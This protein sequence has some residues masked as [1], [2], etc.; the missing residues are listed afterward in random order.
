MRLV[1]LV[2]RNPLF[3]RCT[4]PPGGKCN[5]CEPEIR[6]QFLKYLSSISSGHK[7]IK[8]GDEFLAGLPA[9]MRQD[10]VVLSASGNI[11]DQASP[12]N[13]V[14]IVK[15]PDSENTCLFGIDP[16]QSNFNKIECSSWDGMRGEFELYE[17]TVPEGNK[18]AKT[19]VSRNSRSCISCHTDSFR[20]NWE[21]SAFW[22]KANPPEDR[23]F[24]GPDG[25]PNSFSAAYLDL[26]KRIE[27]GEPRLRQ[28]LPRY[29]SDEIKSVL[30][31]TGQFP[32]A[33]SPNKAN[34]NFG[35]IG[36]ATSL[37]AGSNR[38]N[39][40]RITTEIQKNPNFDSFKY[41]LAGLIYG[42]GPAAS[43]SPSATNEGANKTAEDISMKWDAYKK[44]QINLVNSVLQTYSKPDRLEDAAGVTFHSMDE[45]TKILLPEI[46]EL[47]SP[48]KIDISTWSM[49]ENPSDLIFGNN[50]SLEI[51]RQDWIK[52]LTQEGSKDVGITDDLFTPRFSL[53]DWSKLM[54]DPEK[55]KKY[56]DQLPK[57]C[58]WLHKKSDEAMGISKGPPPPRC[59][60]KKNPTTDIKNLTPQLLR[61]ESQRI[62]N[63]C[64][65]CHE[66]GYK[67]A[68][69]IPYG[70]PKAF[71]EEIKAEQSSPVSLSTKILDRIAR[72][73]SA[74]GHM[75]MN[76][77]NLNS[78]DQEI[79]KLYLQSLA[80]P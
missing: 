67:G 19:S 23:L 55:S 2:W 11:H 75:P 25:K 47:L 32:L 70:D 39:I 57:L 22:A 15:S 54:N 59:N 17:L 1:C 24:S 21:P 5:Q 27:N 68:P 18:S 41:A 52:K 12:G 74:A 16:T 56:F 80:R 31:E 49:S 44:R 13:P 73:E 77:D 8:S 79:L 53:E 69:W 63:K 48:Y 7:K 51:G 72:P 35:H 38:P 42:C 46:K 26:M 28:I 71:E 30:K 78:Q 61:S 4:T 66:T 64:I 58:D 65:G 60:C 6:Q 3:G 45:N 62:F 76:H 43:F 9:S 40:C 37:F 20:V 50:F 10:M 29:S 36:P 33:N 34:W 14:I